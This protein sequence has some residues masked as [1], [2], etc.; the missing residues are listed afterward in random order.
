MIDRY[1]VLL[2]GDALKLVAGTPMFFISLQNGIVC[3]EQGAWHAGYGTYQNSTSLTQSP[4]LCLQWFAEW[5]VLGKYVYRSSNR[6]Q[7][8]VFGNINH[9]VTASYSDNCL[10]LIF[11]NGQFQCTAEFVYCKPSKSE[12][13]LR[14]GWQDCIPKVSFNG[15]EPTG[16]W[17][18]EKFPIGHAVPTGID[19]SRDI[20]SVTFLCNGASSKEVTTVYGVVAGTTDVYRA[21]GFT[22]YSIGGTLI[23][24]DSELSQFL[25]KRNIGLVGVLSGTERGTEKGSGSIFPDP[26]GKSSLHK[27][28][29]QC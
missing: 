17:S 18:L 19:D 16:N 10:N 27:F 11:K 28:P 5:K 22:D 4:D 25:S 13:R 26:S 23:F 9:P 29:M 3:G 24:R 8:L 14:L 21:I 12:E 1:S 7:I 15:S 20:L 2:T 6:Q